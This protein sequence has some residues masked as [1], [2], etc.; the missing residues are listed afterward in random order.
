MNGSLR[1]RLDRAALYA[2]AKGG[3]SIEGACR[4]VVEA[5]G[6]EEATVRLGAELMTKMD[7]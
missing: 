7:E 5:E 6:S 3:A 4:E 1:A 2:A